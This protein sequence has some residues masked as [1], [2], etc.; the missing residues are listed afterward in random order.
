MWSDQDVCL[1][2]SCVGSYSPITQGVQTSA[3]T[4]CTCHPAGLQASGQTREI[5]VTVSKRRVV[6]VMVDVTDILET[7]L[8]TDVCK[9]GEEEECEESGGS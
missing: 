8:L 6:E 9:P 5:S 2:V 7:C 1:D 4:C 3:P